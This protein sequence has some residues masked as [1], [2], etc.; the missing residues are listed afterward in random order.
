M[1]D[2]WFYQ[3]ISNGIGGTMCGGT[4][5]RYQKENTETIKIRLRIAKFL[6]QEKYLEMSIKD[7]YLKRNYLGRGEDAESAIE[8]N[9]NLVDAKKTLDRKIKSQIRECMNIRFPDLKKTSKNYAMVKKVM[10]TEL[11]GY[12]PADL[13]NKYIRERKNLPKK[14]KINKGSVG[15]TELGFET[16]RT[17]FDI[18]FNIRYLPRQEEEK[19]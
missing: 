9:M 3:A 19:S 10:L 17:M 5:D 8:F 16:Y 15:L 14:K 18:G 12:K 4:E 11:S 2:M 13:M 7:G 1:A 6:Q